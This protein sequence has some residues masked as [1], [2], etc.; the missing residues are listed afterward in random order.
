M[1]GRL[2]TASGSESKV[3]SV[4]AESSEACREDDINAEVDAQAKVSNDLDNA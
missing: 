4:E 1:K 3:R 2:C